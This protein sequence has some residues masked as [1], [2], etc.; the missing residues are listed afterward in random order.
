[1]PTPRENEPRDEFISR[2]IPLVIEEGTAQSP[3]QALAICTTFYEDK[4]Q[5]N[6]FLK[7]LQDKF[8]LE[9]NK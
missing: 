3:E 6:D 9:N 8:N 7:L 5:M 2:C 4:T 1:M